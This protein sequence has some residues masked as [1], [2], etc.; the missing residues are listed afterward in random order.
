MSIYTTLHVNITLK[1]DTPQYI[2]D[3]FQSGKQDHRLPAFLDNFGFDFNNKIN[4]CVPDTM[5]FQYDFK[6]F[7]EESGKNYR[8]YLMILMEF[9]DDSFMDIYSLLTTLAAYSEDTKMAG[10]LKHEMGTVDLL[11]FEGG[12]VHWLQGAKVPIDQAEKMK[13]L[14]VFELETLGYKIVN[15]VGTEAEINEMMALFDRNV[16][17][18][19]G[20]N[21]FF[22]PENY[23]ARKDDI[24]KYTPSVEE[25]V[26]KC[27]DYKPIQL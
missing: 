15:A 17:Y 21:L 25:I 20:S 16:P 19:K 9:N 12:F 24:S 23:D 10:Y 18:P 1:K 27:M 5:L 11:A 14:N 26:K 8:H 4:L 2:T 13:T 3:F 6:T 7:S 22:Y